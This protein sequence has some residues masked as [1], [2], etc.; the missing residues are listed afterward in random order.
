MEGEFKM[1]DDKTTTEN[2][3]E[4][5]VETTET[6]QGKETA[7]EKPNLKYT[8]EDVDK[9]LNSKF[10][11]WQK[12][13]EREITEAEKLANMTA[14]DRI[15]AEKEAIEKELSDLRSQQ[16][17]TE[18]TSTARAMLKEQN[19]NIDD[20]LI[21]LLVSDNAENTKANIVLFG[22]SYN[23]AVNKGILARIANP[24]EK[25]GTTTRITKDEI[26]AIKDRSLRQQKIKENMNLFE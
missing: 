15:K 6:T 1:L 12:E 23:E 5:V 17:R 18:M 7:Q 8:D 25:R 11:K 4:V 24:N 20:D 21:K 10:A 14:E 26:M 3:E 13:K 22:N 16:T 2:T 19:I 9:I